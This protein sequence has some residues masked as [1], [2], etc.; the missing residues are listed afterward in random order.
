MARLG[1]DEFAVLPCLGD[2]SE[3]LVELIGRLKPEVER[4]IVYASHDIE[5]AVSFGAAVLP[6]GSSRDGDWLFGAADAALYRAKQDRRGSVLFDDAMRAEME[7][8]HQLALGLKRALAAQELDVFYQ[9]QV[10]LADRRVV[11]FE[12]LVRWHHPERGLLAPGV[13][14][15][16]AE[17]C[18]LMTELT[19]FVVWRVAA[20]I[21][22]WIGMGR[23]PGIVAI[24]MPEAMLAT[25]LARQT[26]DQAMARHGLS[27]ARLGIEVTEN[28]LLNR[29]TTLIIE[30]LRAMRIRG[31]RVSFDDF[32]TGY[33][34]MS[35]LRSFPLDEIKID[36]SFVRDVLVD[37]SSAEIVRS[38]IRLAGKLKKTA[39]AEGIETADQL[40][41]MLE[42]GCPIGQGYLFSPP[43]PFED[44]SA[45]IGQ[46]Q[47]LPPGPTV[48]NEAFRL[49]PL[50][51][52]AGV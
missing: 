5:P 30:T 9:P 29:N 44:A 1:G 40:A 45:M 48:T 28:V 24:N 36:R 18:G 21:A 10:R 35:H 26:I 25:A 42:E 20:D 3:T 17:R 39:V 8:E 52:R 33:A 2:G 43:V 46:R 47:P 6:T 34:S 22:R 41:F 37:G 27:V 32:G 4:T 23:E 50:R 13:F 12:A 14:L 51:E 31:V 7:T 38:L 19:V 15:P 49:E 11:G 16:A